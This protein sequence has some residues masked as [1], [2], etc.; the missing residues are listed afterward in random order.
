MN[1]THWFVLLGALAVGY[2]LRGVFPQPARA[3][4]LP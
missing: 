4:G 3:V 2:V 1:G